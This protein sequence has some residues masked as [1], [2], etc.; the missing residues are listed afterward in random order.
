VKTFWKKVSNG[1]LNRSDKYL[2]LNAIYFYIYI[3]VLRVLSIVYRFAVQLH[4]D[5]SNTNCQIIVLEFRIKCSSS[6][7]S[8]FTHTYFTVL[9][10][11]YINSFISSYATWAI[12]L[13]CFWD[14]SKIFVLVTLKVE[15]LVWSQMPGGGLADW[16]HFDTLLCV[17]GVRLWRRLLPGYWDEAWPH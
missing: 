13:L 14:P 7:H 9:K 4:A 15:Y 17:Y 8:H 16:F 5:T 11:F 2:L 6:A 3:H 12:C 1:I 10:I